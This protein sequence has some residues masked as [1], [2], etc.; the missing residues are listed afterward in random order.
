MAGV[1]RFFWEVANHVTQCVYFLNKHFETH[2]F[3]K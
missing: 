3:G 2:F 1:V